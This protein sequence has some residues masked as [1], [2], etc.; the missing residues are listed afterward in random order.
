MALIQAGVLASGASGGIS[1]VTFCR[2]LGRKTV[3]RRRVSRRCPVGHGGHSRLVMSCAVKAWQG[4][5]PALRAQWET[6]GSGVRSGYC[7]FM[8]GEMELGMARLPQVEGPY[9][10]QP[11]DVPVVIGVTLSAGAGTAMVSWSPDPLPG[12]GG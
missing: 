1:G 8:R 10:G 7:E 12:L 3:R 9:V 6:A 4:L 5:P 2:S 11:S